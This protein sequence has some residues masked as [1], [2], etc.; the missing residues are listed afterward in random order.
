[1]SL[2]EKKKELTKQ[3]FIVDMKD[4]MV[5]IKVKDKNIG[6]VSEKCFECLSLIMKEYG[7]VSFSECF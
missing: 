7:N 5:Y 4:N 6:N 1:M 3:V 2:G